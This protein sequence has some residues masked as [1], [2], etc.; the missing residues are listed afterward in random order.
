MEKQKLNHT[1]SAYW[2]KIKAYWEEDSEKGKSIIDTLIAKKGNKMK[3]NKASKR[4]GK[5]KK[6]KVKEK[7]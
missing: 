2:D 5:Q 7:N 4:K 3:K 1:P 6:E